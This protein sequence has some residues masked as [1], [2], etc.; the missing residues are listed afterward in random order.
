MSVTLNYFSVLTEGED[1]DAQHRA[2]VS[3]ASLDDRLGME[4]TRAMITVARPILDRHRRLLPPAYIHGGI[5]SGCLS[6]H[7]S[8]QMSELASAV[9]S[10]QQDTPTAARNYREIVRHCADAVAEG[11]KSAEALLIE[12]CQDLEAERAKKGGAA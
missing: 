10:G 4:L 7:D 3:K 1:D 2:A 9:A 5:L 12:T 11:A 6:V 8:L